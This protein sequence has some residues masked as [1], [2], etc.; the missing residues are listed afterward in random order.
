[1]KNVAVKEQVQ[2]SGL[3]PVIFKKGLPGLDNSKKFTLHQLEDNPFFYFLQ[4][5]DEQEVGLILLD[6]FLVFPDYSVEL[7]AAERDELEIE[8]RED[9]IVFTTV[10]V[11]T[12]KRMTTNLAAPIVININKNLAKQIVIPERA[13]EMRTPLPMQEK[14]NL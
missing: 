6:P 5:A 1:M 9:V 8:K 2:K 12:R 7:S 3:R 4:S 14:V 10:T 11:P 13:A